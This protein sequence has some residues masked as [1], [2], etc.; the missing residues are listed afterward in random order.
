MTVKN[1]YGTEIDFDV[2]VTYMDDDIREQL[3]RELAPCTEQEFF[4]NYC[5]AH[6]AKFD[7]DW[8]FAKENPVY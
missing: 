8:E 2:A 4:D 1:F 3:H 6:K 7:E 5:K